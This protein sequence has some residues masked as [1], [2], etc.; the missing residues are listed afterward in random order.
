MKGN[1]ALGLKGLYSYLKGGRALTVP[2]L[3]RLV[4]VFHLKPASR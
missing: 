2:L 1:V 3:S 4:K